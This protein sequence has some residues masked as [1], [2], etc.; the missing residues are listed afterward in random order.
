[1][2]ST[3]HTHANNIRRSRTVR[4]FVR[5]W[6]LRFTCAGFMLLTVLSAPAMACGTCGCDASEH[7]SFD[8][9]GTTRGTIAAQHFET[10]WHITEEFDDWELFLIQVFFMEHF[11]PAMML[12]TQQLTAVAM[13]QMVILASFF[14]AKQQLE[15]QRLFEQLKAEAHKDYHPSMGMCVFGTNVRS[16]AAAERRAEITQSI[17]AQRSQDRQSGHINAAGVEGPH[18]D[19]ADRLRRLYAHYCQAHDN[20]DGL[21]A[22][23]T[24]GA[25]GESINRDLDYTRMIDRKMTLEIDLT[26]GADTPEPTEDERDVFALAQNLYA[27][28]VFVRMPESLFRGEVDTNRARWLGVRSLIAKRSV[29]ENSFNAIVGMRAM[30]SPEGGTPVAASG[31]QGTAIGP[32]GSSVDTGGYMQV[33]LRQLGLTDQEEITE[34]LGERPSYYAQMDIL[35]KKMYQRPEFYTDLYD[36]PTNV[37]RKGASL[38]AIGLMQDFDTLKS[39]LRQEMILAVLVEMELMREQE[40]IEDNLGSLSTDGA[41]QAA[42]NTE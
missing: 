30:G 23:C 26:D 20:G 16:L 6:V 2:S 36:T 3:K 24:G 27:H 31:P 13:Q 7:G 8:A 39:Y 40:I 18:M 42:G 41:R 5:A 29:A 14:D 4:G 33:I 17:L 22:I 1:M 19:K 12:M 38:Q 34:L 10:R 15:T 37:D 25:T 35:T 21:D 28:D 11:L 9:A 32:A